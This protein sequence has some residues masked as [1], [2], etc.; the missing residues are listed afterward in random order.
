MT[1]A[2]YFPAPMKRERTRGDRFTGG[3]QT[4]R[5]EKG[6]RE[7]EPQS[8]LL[9]SVPELTARLRGTSRVP[10]P[11]PALLSQKETTVTA[12]LQPEFNG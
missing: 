10:R 7:R 11:L 1:S 5:V 9:P 6:R 2:P 3:T 12:F 8:V 4:R